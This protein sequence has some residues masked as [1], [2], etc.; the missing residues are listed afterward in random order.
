MVQMKV[1][2]LDRNCSFYRASL[3]VYFDIRGRVSV[4]S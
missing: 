3:V 2:D 1:D 4:L